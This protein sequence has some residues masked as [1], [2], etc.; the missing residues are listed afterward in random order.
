MSD[1]DYWLAK[2]SGGWTVETETQVLAVYPTRRAAV[3]HLERLAT[4]KGAEPAAVQALD[5]SEMP[6][7]DAFFRRFS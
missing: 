3:A 4:S 6:Q 1:G 5:L 7:S 2:T